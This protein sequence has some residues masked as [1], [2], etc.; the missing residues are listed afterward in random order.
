MDPKVLPI[1][2]IGDVDYGRKDELDS[3]A[4]AFEAGDQTIARV[5]MSKVTFLDSRG[6]GFLVRLRTAAEAHGGHVE[7]VDPTEAVTSLLRLVNLDGRF[8]VVLS[9]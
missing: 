5:D 8:Q 6:L 9:S 4:G 2:L 7:I 3:I 1:E